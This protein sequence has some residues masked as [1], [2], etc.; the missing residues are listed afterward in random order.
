[1]VCEDVWGNNI[2]KLI[3]NVWFLGDHPQNINIYSVCLG[4]TTT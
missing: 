2:L 4:K 3:Y 1:M